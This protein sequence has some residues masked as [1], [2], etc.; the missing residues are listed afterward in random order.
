MSRSIVE[1]SCSSQKGKHLDF[2]ST[3]IDMYTMVQDTD[4]GYCIPNIHMASNTDISILQKVNCQ[5]NF[6]F[7]LELKVFSIV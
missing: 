4:I 5:M 6:T 7:F 2:T 3:T 1:G